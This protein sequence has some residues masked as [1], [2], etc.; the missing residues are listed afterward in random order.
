MPLAKLS[1]KSQIVLPA[2][3]RR[4]L[5]IRPGDTLDIRVEGERIVIEKAPRSV[6]DALDACGSGSWRGYADELADG[7]HEW[8][9]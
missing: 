9:E 2:Q 4:R 5:N 6:V 8:D 1:S 3:I 7:R